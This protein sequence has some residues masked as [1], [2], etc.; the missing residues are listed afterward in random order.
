MEIHTT[1]LQVC[2]SLKPW[3]FVILTEKPFEADQ[4]WFFSGRMIKPL[5]WKMWETNAWNGPLRIR[6]F[7]LIFILGQEADGAHL[8]GLVCSLSSAPPPMDLASST[9][10]SSCSSRKG[11][12]ASVHLAWYTAFPA[13]PHRKQVVGG[14]HSPSVFHWIPLHIKHFLMLFPET[15]HLMGKAKFIVYAACLIKGTMRMISVRGISIVLRRAFLQ[16]LLWSSQWTA[17]RPSSCS[18]PY[19]HNELWDM[20]I[21]II[22]PST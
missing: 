15:S 2:D 22:I 7:C 10:K 20:C 16:V 1:T 21:N 18:A 5:N 9:W 3:L 14:C 11:A 6:N 12:S 19:I 17:F 13:G 4:I 8:S